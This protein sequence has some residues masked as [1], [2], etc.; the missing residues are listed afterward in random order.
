MANEDQST[1]P[2]GNV[3]SEGV[4]PPP[5]E[6]HKPPRIAPARTGLLTGQASLDRVL[7][8]GLFW[9]LIFGLDKACSLL[10]VVYGSYLIRVPLSENP[11]PLGVLELGACAFALTM[12]GGVYLGLRCCSTE[13]ARSFGQI[14]LFGVG[15]MFLFSLWMWLFP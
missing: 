4:W 15:F 6:G 12:L 8:A 7:G 14:T 9:A 11:L 10:P 1:R 2:K 13:A 3:D 5:P